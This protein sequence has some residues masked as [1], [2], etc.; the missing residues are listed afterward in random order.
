MSVFWIVEGTV[1]KV[2]GITPADGVTTTVTVGSNTPQVVTTDMDGGYSVTELNLVGTVASTGDLVSIVVTDDTGL[3]RGREDFPL[4]NDQLG[5]GGTATVTKDVVTDI[6]VPP[7]SVSVLV[8]EGVIIS[9]DGVNPV[10]DVPL[11][12]TVTVGV[13]S[14]PNGYS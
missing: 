4:T 1:F 11:T 7:R 9:D 8:V 5:E 6:I 10:E 3:E 2:D 14:V 13:Q 12:V